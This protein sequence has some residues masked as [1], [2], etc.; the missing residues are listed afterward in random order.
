MAGRTRTRETDDTVKRRLSSKLRS[1]T[2]VA[3]VKP[4]F[5]P[6]R[7]QKFRDACAAH[8][9]QYEEQ[10]YAQDYQVKAWRDG[11]NERIRL[12]WRDRNFS[13]DES[14]Y[15][16]VGVRKKSLQNQAEAVR[17]VEDQPDYSGAT[18]TLVRDVFDW[19]GFTDKEVLDTL[20]GCKITWQNQ[21]TLE[22]EAGQ[23]PR[24]GRWTTMGE[25]STGRRF[26]TFADA[27]GAGFRSV[28]L[29]AINRIKQGR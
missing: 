5:T 10:W 18:G 21:F 11:G 15:E 4:L 25:S 8:G 28:G 17:F 26:I 12:I 7:I 23:I 9:W 2:N 22:H 29:D 6:T 1:T 3:E 13:G 20:S 14:W 19:D 27:S 24:R 16:L